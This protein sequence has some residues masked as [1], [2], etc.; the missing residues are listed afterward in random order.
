MAVPG[1]GHGR[2]QQAI[3][4]EMVTMRA[5]VQRTKE[6]VKRAGHAY[7]AKHKVAPIQAGAS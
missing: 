4:R 3:L 1:K 5:V 7:D 2:D 6:L